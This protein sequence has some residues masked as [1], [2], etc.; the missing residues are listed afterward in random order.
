MIRNVT[1]L[2]H[3]LRGEPPKTCDYCGLT[4]DEP[5]IPDEADT[6]ICRDCYNRD[7]NEQP[8]DIAENGGVN[9][10]KGSEQ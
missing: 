4:F 8:E 1:R 2:I 3:D 9:I 6:W 7:L 5:R 10:R